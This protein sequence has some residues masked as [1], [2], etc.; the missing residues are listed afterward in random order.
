[1]KTR[2]YRKTPT[3]RWFFTA[4]LAFGGLTYVPVTAAAQTMAFCALR[5]PVIQIYELFPEA[6]GYRSLVRT[7]GEDTQRLVV[8]ALPFGLHF[9]ELGFHTVYQAIGDSGPIGLVHARSEVGPWGLVEV[10]WAFDA[11]MSIRG[12]R[13]QRLRGT[14]SREELE[15]ELAPVLGGLDQRALEGLVARREDL[16]VLTPEATEVVD[17]LVRSAL[18]AIAVTRAGWAP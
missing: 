11:D 18:K 7:I 2:T 4:A 5:D 3:Y 1:M 14:V 9:N 12:F 6:E 16:P 15:R 13:F 10:V 8:D 17:L